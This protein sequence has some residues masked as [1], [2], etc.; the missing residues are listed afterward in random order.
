MALS[1]SVPRC[2]GDRGNGTWPQV[3]VKS[4]RSNTCKRLPVPGARGALRHALVEAFG[5]SLGRS[6]GLRGPVYP[7]PV[8]PAWSPC[9]SG[10]RAMDFVFVKHQ[11]RQSWAC[12]AVLGVLGW[13][14]GVGGMALP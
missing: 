8:P 13:A 7:V 10:C 1:L 6:P 9:L 14:V 3:V 2:K 11:R 12:Q 4:N 5:G